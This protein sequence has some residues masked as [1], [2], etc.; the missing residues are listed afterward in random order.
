MEPFIHHIGI[1]APLLRDNV[2]TDAIIPSRKIRR[3]AKTG[4]EEG[5]FAGWRYLDPS[6]RKPNPDFVLNKPAYQDTS[7]LLSGANFGCGSSREHAVWALKEYGIRAIIASSF[8]RIFQDNCIANGLLPISL[9][10]NITE[11]LTAQVEKDPAKYLLEIDLEKNT[12]T[13]PDG[14][15]HL[16]AIAASAREMLLRGLDPI[17]LT[18]QSKKQI[19]AFLQADRKQRSWAYAPLQKEIVADHSD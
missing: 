6:G 15:T 2:D 11:D 17:A 13:A 16:F 18:L 14:T 7:I 3:V 10:K 19:S 8:G 5:L 9:E 1:A 4:L 12:V